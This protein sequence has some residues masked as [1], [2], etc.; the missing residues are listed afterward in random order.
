MQHQ[1][2]SSFIIMTFQLPLNIVGED[3]E[4]W[5]IIFFHNENR[6]NKMKKN[7]AALLIFSEIIC[8]ASLDFEC[9]CSVDMHSEQSY[10]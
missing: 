3:P 5:I 4:V 2:W 7:V 8:K 10:L 6:E 1:S 9:H